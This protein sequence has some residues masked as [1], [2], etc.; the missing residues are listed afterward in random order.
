MQSIAADYFGIEG[1]ATPLPGYVD[2]N[3]RITTDDGTS[4]VLRVSPSTADLDYMDFMASVLAAAESTSFAIPSVV[5]ST[6]G[7]THV[8]LNDGSVARL[9]TWV[10]GTTYEE[11][12]MPAAA[13]RSIG[14]TAGEM[15]STL[16]ALR[17]G[18]D[19]DP[20]QKWDLRFAAETVDRY[21][22]HLATDMERHIVQTVMAR[23][24][25][26]D[27]AALPRQVVHND[28]N[29][30]NLL[31]EGDAV[32]GLLDFGDTTYTYRI[33]ELAIACAYAT[34]DQD[35]P[36]AVIGEVCAGYRE[37]VEIDKTEARALFDLILTRLA[38]SV[39]IAASRSDANRHRYVTREPTW[40]V[41]RR[42]VP[43]DLDALAQEVASFAVGRE[44]VAARSTVTR[45]MVSPSLGLSYDSPL[46]ITSG[47]GVFLH[48]HR[49]KRFLDCV[50]NVCHVGHAHPHVVKTASRAM[51]TLNTNT[52]Y[53][54]P[55]LPRYAERLLATLPNHLDT[56]FLVNSGSE[57]N[58]LA[59]R[60]ARAAT[61]NNVIACV[62]HG[63][64]GNTSTLIDL[65]PYKFNGRGS[66]GQKSWVRVLPALDPY[67]NEAFGGEDA[68]DEYRRAADCVL[69]GTEL[70]ALVVEALPGCG[71]QIVPTTGA[72]SA[73]YDASRDAGAVVIADEIQ[74]GLGRVGD[75]F[76]A[77]ELFDISPDIVTIGKPAGNG[78]PLAAVATTRNVAD[79]FNNGMEYFNTFG[80]NPVSA[81]VGNA[82]LDVIE[83]EEL[84]RNAATVGQILKK[85]LTALAMNHH[86]IGDVR[87]AGLFIGVD[88]VSDR[89]AK[90]P[91]ATLAH[92]VVEDAKEHGVLLTTDGPSHN[93]IKIKPPLVFSE[94]DAE[95]V[96]TV[97]A[98][99]LSRS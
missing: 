49:A 77:F 41:L 20:R 15:V 88:L 95:R 33:A 40:D 24:S 34:L 54:H 26:L 2:T 52:R 17:A 89:T 38:T 31:L 28:I 5:Q 42:F 55:E 62:D 53:L 22:Q 80:G 51:A 66:R 93:V 27:R 78:H 70:A 7:Q 73:A 6:D 57:A 25:A 82:V 90:T 10:E 64:H 19:P 14:R 8:G 96:V 61:G 56:V 69:A 29:P 83:S 13:A 92:A 37:W 1:M 39:T 9:F 50:N 59:V 85:H 44:H 68:Y 72:L 35:D 3:T 79:A 67:R 16:A 32:V 60:L 99:A 45:P 91:D 74:T 98:A 97:L 23:Y 47:A 18:E 75:R 36:L 58:E 94:R 30:G 11:S 76:W 84:Q 48:D 63:Y 46:T 87:G 65:S 43:T 21:A 81:A 4:Y 12:G 86:A 71:G